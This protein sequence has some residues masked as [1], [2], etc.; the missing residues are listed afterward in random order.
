MISKFPAFENTWEPQVMIAW[1]KAFQEL[2]KYGG[3][4]TN[5]NNLHGGLWLVLDESNSEPWEEECGYCFGKGEWN[6]VVAGLADCHV[7]HGT[8]KRRVRLV[9]A[10]E[11]Q[12]TAVQLDCE[13]WVVYGQK[14]LKIAGPTTKSIIRCAVIRYRNKTLPPPVAA[15][16]REEDVE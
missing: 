13:A 11:I 3:K 6:Y 1:F 14:D 8:G 15:H 16:L 12:V 9:G 7:C 5:L 10:V 4:M 2:M